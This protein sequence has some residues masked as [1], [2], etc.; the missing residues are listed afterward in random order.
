M[1]IKIWSPVLAL[2]FLGAL[3]SVAFAQGEEKPTDAEGCRDSKLVSRMPGCVV[4][5]CASKDFDSTEVVTAKNA[6]MKTLE[7]RVEILKYNCGAEAKVSA[8]AIARNLEGAFK[9][10]GFSVVF[11][12]KAENE[13]PAATVRKGNQWLSVQTL[14]DG[15][16]L[17]YLQ[18]AVL[19]KGM[20]QQMEATADSMAEEIKKSGHVAVYGIN[21]DTG[22]A[23]LKAES[24]KALDQVLQLMKA[25]APLRLRIE[26]H[27]D[28]QGN[29]AANQKLS[30]DRAESVRAWLVKKGIKRDRLEAKGFGASKPVADN[31]LEEGRAKNRR[32]ELVK[33]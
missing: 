21:F 6:E 2:V 10:A 20:E 28:D 30:N 26:G 29:A 31:G 25:N 13:F 32:V 33:L 7:G 17:Y 3:A 27:T 19:V 4:V 22:K 23:S 15:G 16:D 11:S 1:M 18:K 5:E 12:G 8:L 9:K 24:N 14:E